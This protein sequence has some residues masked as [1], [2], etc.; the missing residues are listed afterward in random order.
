MTSRLHKRLA[1]LFKF[2]EAPFGIDIHSIFGMLTLKNK[3]VNLRMSAFMP[4]SCTYNIEPLFKSLWG[5]KEQ[6]I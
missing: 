5:L 1:Y 3:K 6:L 4:S 2:L